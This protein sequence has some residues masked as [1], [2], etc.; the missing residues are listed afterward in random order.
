MGVKVKFRKGA[1]WVFIHH[2]GKR[3]AKLIGDRETALRAASRIRERIAAGA[4]Q[5]PT[6]ADE[7]SVETIAR[8]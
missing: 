8:A 5:L 4:L 6:P 3:K 7:E 2:L 1:W